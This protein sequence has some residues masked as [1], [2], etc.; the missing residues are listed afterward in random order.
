MLPPRKRAA[1]G[2]W[3]AHW[4]SVRDLPHRKCVATV[5]K[6]AKRLIKLGFKVALASRPTSVTTPIA[7]RGAEVVHGPS[8]GPPRSSS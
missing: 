8:V 5:P 6:V 3:P 7:L 2:G 1:A 4:Y